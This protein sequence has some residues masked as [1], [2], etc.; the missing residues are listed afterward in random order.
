M[1]SS[2]PLTRTIRDTIQRHRLL[3]PGETVLLAVSGG[4]DSMV[5][6]D[7]L[8]RCAAED[9]FGIAVAHCN[10]GL[11]GDESDG[12]EAFVAA[13]AG[14]LSVPYYTRRFDTAR[15]AADQKRSVQETA[16]DLRYAFFAEHRQNH[17]MSA[18]AT[19]HHADDNAETILFHLLRGTGVEGLRGIPLISTD[20]S[21]IRPLLNASRTDIDEYAR[22]NAVSFREDSSNRKDD[23]ARNFI[24]NRL[25]PAI[26]AELNPN[27]TETLRRTGMLFSALEQYLATTLHPLGK[28]LVA[29]RSETTLILNRD[30]FHQLPHFLQGYFLHTAGR[31]FLHHEVDW[32]QVQEMLAIAGNET[33]SR[34]AVGDDCHF[35]RNRNQLIFRRLPASEPF[36]ITIE[37]NQ[38]YEF[39]RFFFQSTEAA[40]TEFSNN[41]AIEYIDAEALSGPLLLRTWVEG[42]WFIPLGMS[43]RR[44]LSDFF[45]DEKIP[46]FEKNSVPILVSAGNIVWICGKRLDDRYKLSPETRKALKLEYR[47]R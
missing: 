2:D 40:T 20:R 33:G 30:R 6:L 27:I 3:S 44:K 14:E 28:E 41:R 1:F 38:A 22:R 26:R 12:D 43:H 19:A 9:H 45:I 35:M 42:D 10:H 24:R 21:I 11:R 47:P 15:I 5:M 37:P 39:D 34:M 46:L 17:R 25:M 31:E 13:R 8:H 23:Y 36:S 4:V 7:L 32:R 16:R 29:E 18:V